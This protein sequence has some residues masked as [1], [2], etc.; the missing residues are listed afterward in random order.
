MKEFIICSVIKDIKLRFRNRK[1]TMTFLFFYYI[2]SFF[3]KKLILLL[4][5]NDKKKYM[6]KIIMIKIQMK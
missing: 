3:L 4:Q 5:K 1:N 6:L 2:Y